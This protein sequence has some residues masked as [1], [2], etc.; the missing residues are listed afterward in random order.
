MREDTR[1]LGME[2]QR[3]TVQRCKSAYGLCKSAKVNHNNPWCRVTGT[4]IGSSGFG[5]SAIGSW[6]P[7]SGG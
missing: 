1:A 2:D 3:E 7:G 5:L 4:G 6:H